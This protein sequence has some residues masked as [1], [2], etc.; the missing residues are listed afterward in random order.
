M[1]KAPDPI[2]LVLAA[3]VMIAALGVAAR[4]Q[5][6]GTD[7]PKLTTPEALAPYLKDLEAFP[8]IVGGR[9]LFPPGWASGGTDR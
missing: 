2:S 4:A 6:S 7:R 8:L 1:K 3:G 5:E 9:V